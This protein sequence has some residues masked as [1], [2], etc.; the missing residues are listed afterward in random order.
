MMF[1]AV[2]QGNIVIGSLD[3][4]FDVQAD[5]CQRRPLVRGLGDERVHGVVR[6]PLL[7]D[8]LDGH[9]C[10]RMSSS[11]AN[12]RG[13]ART[14]S[15]RHGYARPRT[16]I[17]QGLSGRGVDNRFV[18][19]S[20]SRRSLMF[21]P[22]RS[23]RSDEQDRRGSVR[24]AQPRRRRAAGPSRACRRRR[25]FR[26]VSGSLALNRCRPSAPGRCAWIVFGDQ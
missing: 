25:E 3:R 13:Y 5:V 12:R 26:E 20:S 16:S 4:L 11:R 10:I 15:P 24:V 14:S 2:S 19:A 8:V 18:S 7:G 1:S 9:Q 6:D 17:A 22:G 21:V 23:S